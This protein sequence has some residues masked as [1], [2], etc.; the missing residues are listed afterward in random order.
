MAPSSMS[1]NQESSSGGLLKWIVDDESNKHNES[2]T[3]FEREIHE[4]SYHSSSSENDFDAYEDDE[5]LR[6]VSNAVYRKE[7]V[8]WNDI[9]SSPVQS[10]YSFT[11]DQLGSGATGTIRAVINRCVRNR[12]LNVD[13]REPSLL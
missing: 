1:S 5:A 4:R 6:G 12:S 3:P 11:S 2:I 7:L 10:V 13:K 9:T 8:L